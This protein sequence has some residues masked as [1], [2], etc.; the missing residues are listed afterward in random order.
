VP[1]AGV[2]V[3]DDAMGPK[4]D[5]TAAQQRQ[6]GQVLYCHYDYEYYGYYYDYCYYYEYYYYST[7]SAIFNIQG[8][9]QLLMNRDG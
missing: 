8:A 6:L 1:A 4:V 2:V 9:L 3:A 7:K 5:V